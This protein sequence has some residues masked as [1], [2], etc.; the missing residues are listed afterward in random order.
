MYT[1]V[2]GPHE[3]DTAD[4]LWVPDDV[5]KAFGIEPELKDLRKSFAYHDPDSDPERVASYGF[6]H[7]DEK[8]Q[9]NIR[10]CLIGIA[11]LNGAKHAGPSVEDDDARKAVYDHLA[12]HLRDAE[13]PVPDLRSGDG[14]LKMN[15][16]AV[17][18]L[19][20]LMSFSSYAAEVGAS[21]RMR[22]KGLTRSTEMI[23]GWIKEELK[24]LES[25]VDDPNAG[26]GDLVIQ[27]IRDQHLANRL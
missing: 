5:L 23:L 19:A 6:L 1:G 13:F 11:G 20:D 18:V 17:V 12:A 22:G 27:R 7:H 3:T 8:G 25:I 26:L 10:A 24:R 21:R 4:G 15:D 9:A 2:I 14:Q 16:E